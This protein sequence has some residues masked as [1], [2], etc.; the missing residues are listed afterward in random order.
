M[1]TKMKISKITFLIGLFCLLL[2]GCSN[3]SP[4]GVAKEFCEAV[5]SGNFK[6]AKSLCTPQSAA[7]IDFGLSV[8]RDED[9]KERISSKVEA[10]VIDCHIDDKGETAQVTVEVKVND[11]KRKEEIDLKK[12]DGEWKVAF[13]IK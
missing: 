13:K 7:G 2:T 9:L 5:Y 6:K 1:M 11:D 12:I 4:E 10:N 3:N 8:M